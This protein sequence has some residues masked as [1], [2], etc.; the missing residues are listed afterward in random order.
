MTGTN[1]EDLS[2]TH[3][4][5][6][7]TYAPWRRL[8]NWAASSH[9]VAVVSSSTPGAFAP[10]HGAKL[11]NVSTSN[12]SR[13]SSGRRV[14]LGGGRVSSA[15][16]PPCGEAREKLGPEP[17][18]GEAGRV[19]VM[20]RTP[21]GRRARRPALALARGDRRI[22]LRWAVAVRNGGRAH[23]PKAG[24]CQGGGWL[25]AALGCRARPVRL[26]CRRCSGIPPEANYS[27]QP[28]PR[29]I[30]PP[31]SPP[32]KGP[33]IALGGVS[34]RP[35][36]PDAKNLGN[37]HRELHHELRFSDLEGCLRRGRSARRRTCGS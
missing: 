32:P 22:A 3:I 33:K 21:G 2:L 26:G 23:F 9:P 14:G 19:E 18:K 20:I 35:V 36:R 16:R 24:Q 27:P 25:R 34:R 15:A 10:R 7:P 12:I 28:R 31:N 4:Y 6:R 37:S 5:R 30:P 17:A 11:S 1:R 8:A 29:M 13:R